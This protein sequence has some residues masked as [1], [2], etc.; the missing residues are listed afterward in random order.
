MR[1]TLLT[2]ALVL[3]LCYSALAGDMHTPPVAPDPP[4]PSQE[5]SVDAVNDAPG[6]LTQIAL[7]LLTLLPSLL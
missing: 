3:A 6:G 2:A 1:K 5:Q 4:G 7:D